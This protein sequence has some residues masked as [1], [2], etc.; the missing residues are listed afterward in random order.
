MQDAQATWRTARLEALGSTTGTHPGITA[1][2]DIQRRVDDIVGQISADL[3]D[4]PDGGWAPTLDIG[5]FDQNDQE[6]TR[7][8]C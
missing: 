3:D 6:G 4:E 2:T 7:H 8:D 1:W 5:G